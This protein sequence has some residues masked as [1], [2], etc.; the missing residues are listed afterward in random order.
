MA[1]GTAVAVIGD[2]EYNS[3][4]EA[5]AEAIKSAEAKTIKLLSDCSGS[6]IQI[7]KDK[8]ITIDFDGHT[9]T[10]SGAPLAGSSGT[11][12]QCF[13][14]LKDSNIKFMN[15]TVKVADE[16]SG[17]PEVRFI[18][19]NYC[20]LTL[21][22]MVLD[23]TKLNYSAGTCYTLSNN[24]GNVIIKDTTITAKEGDVAFDVC[25]YASYTGPCVTVQGN[26]IINGKVEISSSGAKEGAIHKLIVSGATFNGEIVKD[27]SSPDFSAEITKGTFAS[28]VT[29]YAGGKLV[30]MR[31]TD[32]KYYVGDTAQSALENAAAGER[33]HVR[34]A[35]NNTID[36]VTPGVVL[37]NA[38]REQ[39]EMALTVNGK[40]YVG[41]EAITAEAKTITII[42]PSEGGGTATTPETTKNPGTGAN[43]FVGAAVAVAVISAV[44]AAAV[45]RKK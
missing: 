35:P 14:L 2:V 40:T 7:P 43:D 9:Y 32:N 8:N 26:S 33:F 21:E 18:I 38:I 20:N 3:L 4:S 42:V 29:A 30:I 39:E 27:G 37:I 19:Q 11:E 24:N 23:G 22:N 17:N 41:V 45:V 34:Q 16:Y 13:Q 31:E 6:G 12:N 25:R 10:V 15:G 36:N 44:G 5:V 28:D 1:E